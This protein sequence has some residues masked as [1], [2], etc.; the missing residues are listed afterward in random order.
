MGD[1]VVNGVQV[2]TLTLARDNGVSTVLSRNIVNNDDWPGNSNT[3]TPP[4]R[5][6]ISFTMQDGRL[7]ISVSVFRGGRGG[8]LF[9]ANYQTSLNL[10]SPHPLLENFDPNDPSN[11][12]NSNSS[13]NNNNDNDNGSGGGSS[14]NTGGGIEN[15]DPDP[16]PDPD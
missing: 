13:N 7:N 3:R 8:N 1:R 14:G 5:R 15:P 9:I 12:N 2:G 4:F 10:A 6:G 16:T 11:S